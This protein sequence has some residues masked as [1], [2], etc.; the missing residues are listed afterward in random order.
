MKSIA[1]FLLVAIFGIASAEKSF[2][3]ELFGAV[4]NPD[5]KPQTPIGEFIQ[6]L[7]KEINVED[8]QTNVQNENQAN[9]QTLN[10]IA[11][12]KMEVGI[13][14][15]QTELN[16]MKIALEQI[17]KSVE[18]NK[19]TFFKPKETKRTDELVKQDKLVEEDELVQSDESDEFDESNNLDWPVHFSTKMKEMME[20]E[21]KK[22][23]A[24]QKRRDWIAHQRFLHEERLKTQK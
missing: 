5:Y 20:A 16:E 23:D 1:I 11:I 13:S 17:K 3:E 21:A 4:G 7:K 19:Q 6:K 9:G 8:E 12:E 14:K 22:N 24:T 18:E 10:E 15:M 2:L